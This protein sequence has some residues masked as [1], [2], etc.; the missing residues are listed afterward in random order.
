MRSCCP[1]GNVAASACLLLP[2]KIVEL[3]VCLT[4]LYF[5]EN[6]LSKCD[7]Y[8]GMLGQQG[9]NRYAWQVTVLT[10]QLLGRKERIY[11]H[12]SDVV[13]EATD[14]HWR[15]AIC[16]KGWFFWELFFQVFISFSLRVFLL[17]LLISPCNL[18]VPRYIF[19]QLF[20]EGGRT[21]Y[22]YESW[23]FHVSTTASN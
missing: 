22:S 12:S 23:I 5:L 8:R 13:W 1:F 16:Y 3:K 2:G 15:L 19:F 4:P 9:L 6:I 17:A 14:K 11:W 10:C 20:F 7:L 18:K 21:D